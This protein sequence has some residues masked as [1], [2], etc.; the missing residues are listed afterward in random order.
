MNRAIKY[1][2]YPTDEQK[3]LFARTFGCG[4]KVWNL[5]LAD[6]IKAYEETGMFPSLTPAMYKDEYPYL[7]EVDSLALA[8]KQLDL[9]AAFKACFSKKRKTKNGFPK[10]KSAKHSKKSYTTNNQDGTIAIVEGRYIK[11]PKVGL[12][13]AEIHRLPE[14][15]WKLK[16]A[17]VSQEGDGSYY[18]SVLFEFCEQEGSHAIDMSNSIGIDYASSGLYVDNNGNTGSNHKYY[19]ESQEKL[20]R[21]QRKLSRKVGARK[22]E[23]PSNNYK[24]QQLRVNKIHRHIANQRKDSLHKKSTE[25]A[26][27]YDVVCAETLDM[28]AIANRKEHLGKATYD[29]GYGMFLDMLEYKMAERGKYLVRVDKWFPSSQMCN[30]CGA[31]HPEM[32]DLKVR[33]ME[34]ECGNHMDRNQNAAINILNEGLRILEESL[35]IA[36]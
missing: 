35:T 19:A 1:R 29:N 23:E 12:V 15:G 17:T 8:N 11:L 2:V 9:E 32:K 21:E 13:R 31:I 22:G 18:V 4:R 34:C 16:S 6:K 25:I 3:N 10:F 33:I 28:K 5:M 14:D 36:S 7:R 27:R 24:K 26:N 20:A 30:R